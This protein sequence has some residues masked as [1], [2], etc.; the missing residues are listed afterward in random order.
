MTLVGVL[1]TGEEIYIERTMDDVL[2]TGADGDTYLSMKEEGID[3]ENEKKF[4]L[5][6]IKSLELATLNPAFLIE[7]DLLVKNDE[8]EVEE[9]VPEEPDPSKEAD[10]TPDELKKEEPKE[11]V[12][13]KVKESLHPFSHHNLSIEYDKDHERWNLI[14]Y[15]EKEGY[16]STLFVFDEEEEAKKAGMDIA[17]VIPGVT[18]IGKR[19][20]TGYRNE[21]VKKNEAK[22][23][24]DYVKSLKDAL[25]KAREA[26][27][28]KDYE[29][30]ADALDDVKDDADDAARAARKMKRDAD[31]K[32]EDGTNKEV[33]VEKRKFEGNT[34]SDVLLKA[35]LSQENVNAIKK[36]YEGILWDSPVE[37]FFGDFYGR[38]I[39]AKVKAV[40]AG[41]YQP[42]DSKLL[43]IDKKIVDSIYYMS[44]KY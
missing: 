9:E 39:V 30:A 6:G 2:F 5:D 41:K 17:N 32:E 13:K 33:T 28:L 15:N 29:A 4:A 3:P 7:Y 31:N 34:I 36:G 10:F 44:K 16:F 11:S 24:V 43:N 23:G 14:G 20:D 12:K 40:L 21:S 38:D 19:E 25:K 18:Y 42:W 37:E 35:G 26:L 1:E 8:E 22:L 27:K